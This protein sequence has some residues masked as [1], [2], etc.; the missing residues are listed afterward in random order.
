MI[1]KE[2]QET[3]NFAAME[4]IKRRHEYVT[5]EHL[6]YALLHERTAAKVV[7]HCG[8][9][10]NALTKE[11]ETFFE[12]KMESVPAS[13]DT[14]PEYTAAFQRVVE[15]AVL[16]AEGS[17]QKEVDGGNVLAALFQSPNSHAVYM[18]RKQGITRL[19][20][21][22]YLAHGISKVEGGPAGGDFAEEAEGEDYESEQAARDP[23]K[24]FAT[25]LV[26]RAAEGKI[27]PLIGREAEVARTIQV[28]CRRRKNNP[29]YV[30]DPGVGKTA[31]A[32]GL[33]LKI[34]KGEVP[35][36]LKGA[37][38][39]SLDMGAL[40]AGTKYRGEFEQRLK[41]VIGALKKKENVILFIDEIHTI[42]GAG[43]V[44]GGT[45]DASNIIKP[46]LASG[47]MRCIGS[48][49]YPEYK[50]AF[51]RDRAL[52]RRFQKIEVSEPTLEDTV[53]ILEGLKKLYEEAHGVTYSSA[54]LRAAAELAAK[55]I[56]DRFLPDKAIDVVDEV[57]AMVKL[58]PAEERPAEIGVHEIE[59][60]VARIAK[61]PP[62]T[63]KGTEKDRLQHLAAALKGVIYGQDHAIAQMVNAIKLSRSGLGHPDKPIGSFLFS[64]PTGV[65]KTELAKQLALALGVEFIRFDMSEYAEPHTV[66]R[67]IGAPPGYVGFDQGGLLTDAV[68]KTPYAVV[69]LD[70]IEKAHPNL[71]NILLQVMDHATLTDNNGKRAD[72]HNVILI[73][74]TNAGAR[75]MS[76][77]RI[78]FQK[79]QDGLSQGQGRGAIERTF[80]P[81]F[82]NRL[83]AWIAFAPLTFETI[84][85]V[86]DKFINEVR[87]QLVEKN[88]ELKLTE[89]A[90]RWLAEHGYDKQMGARPMARLIQEKI[91][92]PLAEEIL[93]GRLQHG[94][95]AVVNIPDEE[96][97][98][99]IIERQGGGPASREGSSLPNEGGVTKDTPSFIAP[100]SI[101]D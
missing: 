44:S 17:G 54:A 18:L 72:F 88:V 49:T 37:E 84:E 22:N 43:A 25:D 100:P 10:A 95:K 81:E 68:N 64:G 60:V 75:E 15:Y 1:T 56:H 19:D 20:I 34:Q 87:A 82:R 2:L 5:L 57:G 31:I 16:Q 24:A 23:L 26:A 46:V 50:A 97:R 9:D 47:E 70:E 66:S 41:A 63:I 78:G 51:E 85:R 12:E 80:S 39:F 99:E 98:I 62:R 90:R 7:R 89:H 67:L 55:H 4:A 38:V 29:I 11:L 21:L 65:G 53:K 94:G 74:T 14:L 58:M 73:M 61:I 86:V 32:E 92:A 79:G 30:G 40:L 36:A 3:L 45:M 59:A 91:K 27:D 8:G 13:S 93:F 33:A 83:D 28:L 42:V 101:F 35:D 71:F 77:A 76:D 6:L 96:L 69:V 52:A 48:T